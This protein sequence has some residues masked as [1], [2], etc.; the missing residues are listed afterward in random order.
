MMDREQR[1]ERRIVSELARLGLNAKA[2]AADVG[3][4]D[5]G[6]DMKTDT[7]AE[8]MVIRERADNGGERHT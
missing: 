2:A 1:C 3:G 6:W 4:S 8:F 5:T 7:G